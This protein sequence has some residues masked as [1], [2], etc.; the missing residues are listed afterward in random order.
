MDFTLAFIWFHGFSAFLCIQ[1]SHVVEHTLEEPNTHDA[2]HMHDTHVGRTKAGAREEPWVI[3]SGQSAFEYMNL[4]PVNQKKSPRCFRA[5]Y[6]TS[7]FM[8]P[9]PLDFNVEG[10]RDADDN[11]H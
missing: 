1:R 5:T 9:A 11:Q 6:L 2:T 10:N 7:T 4:R 3:G 8:N